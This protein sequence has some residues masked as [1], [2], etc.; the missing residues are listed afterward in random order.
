MCRHVGTDFRSLASDNG[1]IASECE[2]PS[3]PEINEDKKTA[4]KAERVICLGR[5][6]RPIGRIGAIYF[7]GRLDALVLQTLADGERVL[8]CR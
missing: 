2:R 4:T 6:R 5:T 7:A 1:K 8:S 3:T